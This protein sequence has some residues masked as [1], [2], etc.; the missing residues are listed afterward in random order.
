MFGTLADAVAGRNIPFG[1]NLLMATV[2]GRIVGVGHTIHIESIAVH[3]DLTAP[4]HDQ[5]SIE[6]AVRP[7]CIVRLVRPHCRRYRGRHLCTRTRQRA[8]R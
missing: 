8:V 1:R 3:H 6:R 7:L 2:D 5:E 4:A